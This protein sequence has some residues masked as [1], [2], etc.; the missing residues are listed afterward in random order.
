ML[1]LQGKTVFLRALE[2]ED[3][4]LLFS[5]ENNQDFWEISA[6]STPYSRFI[7]KQY[8]K[9]SHKDI[10][11]V[12][13]LR[14]AICKMDKTPIGFIDLFNFEPKNFRAEIGII[15]ASESDWGKGFAAEAL[16]ILKKYCFSQ[17]GLHQV[18]AGVGEE[19]L[20]SQ[21][22]F[23]K[24]GF[25]KTGHKKEW[26]FVNGAFKAELFYQFIKDVH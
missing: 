26:N 19:N 25:E 20:R 15:I 13:Q 1:A 12:K 10:Y 7:L 17:L 4:E 9:N 21:Q 6:T 22:L 3:L 14:L 5:V 16:E 11:E 18:C 24:A 2:P 23:E 8:L